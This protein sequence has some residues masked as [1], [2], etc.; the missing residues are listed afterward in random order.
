MKKK[1]GKKI[2]IIIGIILLIIIALFGYLVIEDL[3][4]EEILKQE[5]VNLSNKD[6]E[7]DDYK[8]SVKTKGDY[9]Y[10]E[11]S[12]KK[13][14]KELSDNVKLLNQSITS[15]NFTEILSPQT[16]EEERPNFEN[17][18]KTLA[19]SK[20]NT[21][22]AITNIS[23]LC[24][25]EYIKKLIDKEKVDDYSYDLF[26]QLMYT[27]EDLKELN[28]LKKEMQDLSNKTENFINKIEEIL[29]LL[30]E[31]NSSF[32]IKNNQIYF[33]TNELV[34]KYNQ[35]YK[36]LQTILEEIN[37]NSIVSEDKK[38]TADQI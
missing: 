24:D 19:K 5:I 36:D 28:N 3:K 35:L 21:K 27:K 1:R 25:E 20:E 16:L 7:K 8:I 30:K 9:A 15:D 34:E 12:I 33:S 29:N 13:Y 4:Q 18:Y 22:T 2:I 17:K 6:L 23:L 26:L 14:Y 38:T 10:I 31:N 11:E 37:D 32:E